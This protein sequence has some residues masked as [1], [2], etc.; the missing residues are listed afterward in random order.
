MQQLRCFWAVMA[1]SLSMLMV[2]SSACAPVPGFAQQAAL[3]PP[4]ATLVHLQGVVYQSLPWQLSLTTL[5]QGM[6]AAKLQQQ[7]QAQLDTLD[8][9]LS[10]FRNDSEL[11]SFNRAP[12]GRWVV[13]SPL[14]FNSVRTAVEVSALSTGAYDI[15]V[16]PLVELWGF[17][18]GDSGAGGGAVADALPD[19]AVLAAAQARV[20]WQHIGIKAET[21]ALMRR[22][23]IGLDLSSLG[24]GVAVDV[25]ADFLRA[26]G[27]Q[28]YLLAVAGTMRAQGHKPDGSAWTVAIEH[29][30]GSSLPMH[31]LHVQE[32]L[33]STSGSYRRYRTIEGQTYSHTLDPKTGWPI[34]HA[35]V[36]VTL[37]APLSMGAARV[38]ALATALN[39]LGPEAGLRLAEAQQL[40]VLFIERTQLGLRQRASSGFVASFPFKSK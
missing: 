17:G 22:A 20:G 18:A 2:M 13:V 25:M 26:H 11:M 12:L 5:P 21:S 7:L 24:E 23:D 38:D 40:S 35:G 39:V 15:T 29:P 10:T 19:A 34:R 4:A 28:D 9:S 36:S 30:D 1:I 3:V 27:V 32:Q 16:G 14:L 8:Q 33:V 31:V 37:V 6:S